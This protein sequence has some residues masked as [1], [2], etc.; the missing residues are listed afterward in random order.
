MDLQTLQHKVETS[1]L[2]ADSE[3]AYWSGNLVHMNA[4]QLE[5]LEKILTE[6]EG[7]SWNEEMQQYIAIATKAT[8]VLAAA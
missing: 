2:L 4:E 1:P 6:A 5:K 3:R 7:L 8:A